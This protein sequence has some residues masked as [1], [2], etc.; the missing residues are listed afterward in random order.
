M[1]SFFRPCKCKIIFGAESGNANLQRIIFSERNANSLRYCVSK[2]WIFHGL[3]SDQK[4]PRT[5]GRTKAAMMGIAAES[6]QMSEAGA[7]GEARFH[8]SLMG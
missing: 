5:T 4:N 6:G 7:A 8:G 1:N 2:R 3:I